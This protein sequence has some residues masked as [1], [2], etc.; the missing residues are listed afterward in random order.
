VTATPEPGAPASLLHLLRLVSPALPVGGYTYSQGLEYAVEAG[1]V[2]SEADTE[3]WMRG[4]LEAVMAYVDAPL[5]LRLMAAFAHRDEALARR[6][7]RLALACRE[8]AELRAEE[9]RMGA[10]LARLLAD[11][12]VGAARP[13]LRSPDAAFIT[14]FA[15][16]S[17]HWGIDPRT[18]LGGYLWAWTEAR[19]AAAVKLVPLGQTAGQ[20]ILIR[21]A[22]VIPKVIA[23]A[24]YLDDDEIGASAPG[25]AIA[26]ACHETQY[27]R[28]F[29]S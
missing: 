8:A 10:S 6:W 7:S 21:T 20:R 25:L 11:L 22:E 27:S 5:L 16:A 2:A 15:L 24:W 13:W 23:S 28:L 19:V 26:S 9:R 18:A 17:V 1:W 29:R 14:L 12:G 4:Q 3:D